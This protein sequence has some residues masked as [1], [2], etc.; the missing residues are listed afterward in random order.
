[1]VKQRL[2]IAALVLAAV[3]AT[4][5]VFV[6]L[7][8]EATSDSSG[9]ETTAAVSLL[10]SMGPSVF[11]IV[12]IPVVIA[13]LPLFSRGRTWVVLSIVSAALLW[14]F[15]VL[16]ALS[17]GV[18]FMPAAI[19]SLVAACIPARSLRAPSSATT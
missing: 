14:T 12:A 18:F 4:V 11:L 10:Q 9:N 7:A 17:I 19:L 3:A 5:V 16:G 15:V 1:M 2:Q 8:T 13:A 6:P